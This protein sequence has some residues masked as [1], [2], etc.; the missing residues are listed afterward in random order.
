MRGKRSLG[1][2]MH[3]VLQAAGRIRAG[4]SRWT[5]FCVFHRNGAENGRSSTQRRQ[6]APPTGGCV[7]S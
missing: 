4:P 1:A 3:W 5:R 7:C 2:A 6:G